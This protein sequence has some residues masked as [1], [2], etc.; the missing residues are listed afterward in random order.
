MAAD[1]SGML[2]IDKVDIVIN[3]EPIGTSDPYVVFT[4]NGERVHKSQVVKKSLN[5]TWKNE[6]FTVPIVRIDRCHPST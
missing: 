6:Q 4:V 5:P 3:G 1:K 2:L